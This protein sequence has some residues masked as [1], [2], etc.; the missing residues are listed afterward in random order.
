M[1][2]LELQ[3]V[4]FGIVMFWLGVVAAMAVSAVRT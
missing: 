4:A 1:T 2:R 3:I